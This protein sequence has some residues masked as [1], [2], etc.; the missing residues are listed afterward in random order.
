MD[1]VVWTKFAP[2]VG[3]AHSELHQYLIPPR[4][5][6]T[7][8]HTPL[9]TLFKLLSPPHHLQSFISLSS[10]PSNRKLLMVSICIPTLLVMLSTF[11]LSTKVTPYCIS[12]RER[13][14]SHLYQYSA[15]TQKHLYHMALYFTASRLETRQNH[16]F[17]MMQQMFRDIA[18]YDIDHISQYY[19]PLPWHAHIHAWSPV[20]SSTLPIAHTPF[21]RPP[22]ISPALSSFTQ[23]YLELRISAYTHCVFDLIA[24]YGVHGCDLDVS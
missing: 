7:Y 19:S 9:Y 23:T 4:P 22:Y 21:P 1:M 5:S 2:V 3:H 12:F 10:V 18:S 8:P 16:A 6:S 17:G 13:H 24:F 20:I 14:N 11:K 15:H